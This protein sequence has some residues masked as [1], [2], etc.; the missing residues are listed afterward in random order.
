MATATQQP[1]EVRPRSDEWLEVKAP[2]Q[3]QF[4]KQGEMAVGILLS[5]EPVEIKGKQ[6]IEYMFARVN[7]DRFTCL[8]TNDLNKKIQPGHIGHLMRI[9]Y[10]AD[11][12]SFQK[13]GQNPMKVFK[14]S[15]KAEKEPT[16]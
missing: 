1:Q 8:G 3:F 2:E 10:E 9:R 12:N 15:V 14:V 7:G 4:T 16:L 6:A 13:Q 11:D 5:I